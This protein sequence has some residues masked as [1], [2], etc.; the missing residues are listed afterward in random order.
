MD[1]GETGNC[2]VRNL[3]GGGL[4]II[5]GQPLPV[6]ARLQVNVTPARS[7]VSPLDAEAEVVRV[8]ATDAGFEIGLAVKSF[9]A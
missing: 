2:T 6:G 1:T 7:L 5:C 3:S 8:T 4:L 9:R